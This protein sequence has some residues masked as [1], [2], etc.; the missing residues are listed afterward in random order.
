MRNISRSSETNIKDSLKRLE[1]T[2]K[3]SYIWNSTTLSASSRM[4]ILAVRG[5]GWRTSTTLIRT[6]QS[7]IKLTDSKVSQWIV[8]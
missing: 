1:L 2:N 8:S 3:E 4:I 7:P 5:A 6:T